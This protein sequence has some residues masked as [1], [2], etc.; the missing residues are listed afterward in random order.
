MFGKACHLYIELEHKALWALKKLNINWVDASELRV[1][2]LY[3]LEIFWLKEY[4]SVVL[5]KEK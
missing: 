2:Q 1:T 3:E 4:K 5:Y